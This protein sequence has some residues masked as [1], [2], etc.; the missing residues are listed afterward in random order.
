ME[1]DGNE[2]GREK[3][4]AVRFVWL[5]GGRD[6]RVSCAFNN[7]ATT[8]QLSSEGAGREHVLAVV[9]LVPVGYIEYAFLVDGCWLSDPQQARTPMGDRNWL[10]ARPHASFAHH[11]RGALSLPSASVASPVADGSLG[12]IGFVGPLGPRVAIEADGETATKARVADF[13]A[14]RSVIE[15]VP[16][17]GR[18]V[19]FDINMPVQQAFHVLYEQGIHSAPLWDPQSA[20]FV[21]VLASSDFIQMLRALQQSLPLD[22]SEMYA[23]TIAEWRNA[24]AKE[25]QEPRQLVS[26]EPEVSMLE[27]ARLITSEVVSNVPVLAHDPSPDGCVPQLLHMASLSGVLAC[28]AKH[29]RGAP[30]ALPLLSR[31]IRSLPLGTWVNRLGGCSSAVTDC[32][33]NAAELGEN[34]NSSSTRAAFGGA[35]TPSAYGTTLSPSSSSPTTTGSGAGASTTTAGEGGGLS[36][37]QNTHPGDSGFMQN[38]KRSSGPNSVGHGNSLAATASA[39]N[40]ADPGRSSANSTTSNVGAAGTNMKSGLESLY[41]VRTASPTT[42]LV[43]ALEEMMESGVGSLPVVDSNGRLKD[44]YARSDVTSLAHESAY[45]RVSLADISVGQALLFASEGANKH[46]SAAFHQQ[47]VHTCTLDDQLLDVL[48]TLAVPDVRRVVCVE[49]STRRVEGVMTLS[50]IMHLLL[51]AIA[52]S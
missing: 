39:P 24:C 20:A 22:E 43:V 29:F 35:D 31:P 41:P 48:E 36:F 13:L 21:G 6:V 33:W 2:A 26:I 4:V 32:G 5:H 3:E 45:A 27:F 23:H 47:K 9:M 37:P 17:S 50:D 18:V 12:P 42:S 15:M 10:I 25:G 11:E 1:V 38:E 7:W 40:T 8:V 46:G 34:W 14:S 16:E 52:P 19:A 30:G 49:P 51:P 28:I 44:L